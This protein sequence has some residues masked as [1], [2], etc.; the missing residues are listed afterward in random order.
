VTLEQRLSL[1]TLGVADM[2]RARTFYTTTLGWTPFF[3]MDD[4][5]FFDM[6]GPCSASSSTRACRKT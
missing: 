1:V 2:V 4:I 5:V 6:G 3:E